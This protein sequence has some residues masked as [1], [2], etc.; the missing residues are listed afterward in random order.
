MQGYRLPTVETFDE[1]LKN[2]PGMLDH[3][4]KTYRSG[5][6]RI[7]RDL[8]PAEI[9]DPI[10]LNDYRTSMKLGTRNVFNVTWKHLREFEAA[11]GVEIAEHPN[12]PRVRFA[13]PLMHDL[14]T[15]TG[16]F[17]LE[18]TS[19]LTWG[20]VPAFAHRTEVERAL[21]RVFEFQT[22]RSAL[23]ATADTPLVPTRHGLPMR[24]WQ[25]EF[26]VNSVHHES[27][28]IVDRRAKDLA[29]VLVFAGVNGIFLRDCMT[30]LWRARP[31]L[32]RAANADELMESFIQ[33]A[34]DRQYAIL[35]QALVKRETG[36]S[37]P[38]W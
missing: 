32:A 23:E 9:F 31:N 27:D 7:L 4:R 17:S 16:Y 6:R 2:R 8:T 34:K 26:I 37:L 28:H 30:A 33:L 10:T 19:E 14:L 38:A 18:Q 5:Y 13:H 20:S 35:R 21:E 36:K 25:L 1:H 22:G 29:E 3:A 12:M 24:P 15:L 11:R